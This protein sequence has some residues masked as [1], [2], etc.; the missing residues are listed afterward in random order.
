MKSSLLR[1]FLV[2]AAASLLCACGGNQSLPPPAVD[3]A[4]IAGDGSTLLPQHTCHWYVHHGLP[5]PSSCGCPATPTPQPSPW[6]S[7][8]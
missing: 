2:G 4:A 1:L 3:S 5:E 7:R 6:P 8:R